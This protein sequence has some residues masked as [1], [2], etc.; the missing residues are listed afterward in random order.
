MN[1]PCERIMRKEHQSVAPL[2]SVRIATLVNLQHA[3]INVKRQAKFGSPKEEAKSRTAVF[4]K[5]NNGKHY[6]AL[7]VGR[8]F[9]SQG[10][11][12]ELRKK[13]E[14]TTHHPQIHTF[15]KTVSTNTKVALVFV[16]VVFVS[17]TLKLPYSFRFD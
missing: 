8:D 16:F 6:T 17:P 11:D 1:V 2:T 5:E 9:T 13:R 4:P 7:S 15:D 3:K 12:L 14:G 10:K